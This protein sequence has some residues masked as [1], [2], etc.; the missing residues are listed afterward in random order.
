M[1]WKNHF[2]FLLVFQ[3]HLGQSL[4]FLLALVL[5][6]P[7]PVTVTAATYAADEMLIIDRKSELD[8]RELSAMNVKVI[9]EYH[10]FWIAIIR[11]QRVT[12]DLDAGQYSFYSCGAVEYDKKYGVALLRAEHRLPEVGGRIL[13][14]RNNLSVIVFDSEKQWRHFSENPAIFMAPLSFDEIA[15]PAVIPDEYRDRTRAITVKPFVQQMVN[16]ATDTHIMNHWE[17]IIS[18]ATT[19]YSTSTGCQTASEY[20][21]SLFESYS[22]T[23][24]FQYHSTG[25]APN[26][27]AT[28]P[29]TVEPEKVVIMIGHLDDLPSN[30]VAPGADD[31][32]SGSATVTALADIMSNYAFRKTVKFIAVTGEEFG[33][34]GSSYYASTAAA[35]GE[36][37]EAV[38]N[39]DMTGWEGDGNP[40]IENLD[41]NYNTNSQWLGELF[42]DAASSYNTGCSVNLL[43][44]P[45]LTASD[46]AP[47][48]SRG[49]SALCG[50]TDNEGYCGASGHYPYYHTSNDTLVNCGNPAFFQKTVRAYL[51]TLAHLADP[52]CSKPVP[53]VLQ[54]AQASGL[55]EVS[56]SWSS[57]GPGNNYL[58]FRSPGGCS[59][60]QG[61]YQVGETTDTSFVDES[62]SGDV[63]YAY[64]IRSQDSTGFCMSGPGNCLEAI[65]DG[66]CREPPVFS[67]LRSA[68]DFHFANCTIKLEWLPA[69]A[70]CGYGVQYN[71]Y[72]S[73]VTPFSPG[74]E[75]VL[76]T[77]IIGEVFY[78]TLVDPGVTYYYIVRSEDFS[79]LGTGPMGGN[80]DTN[81]VIQATRAS[82]PVRTIFSENFESPQS[83]FD[84]ENP[85][86]LSTAE[87]HSGQWSLFS[88]NEN[89]TCSR[90]SMRT[91]VSLEN[92]YSPRLI[93][94]S[95]YSIEEDYDGYQAQISIDNGQNW[96]LLQP[97]NG[98]P[99][100]ASADCQ[101]KIT[102]AVIS[103]ESSGWFEYR[104]DLT[105]YEGE[106]ILIR[107]V[108]M[109]D[110]YITHGGAY[111]DDVSIESYEPC[112]ISA[113]PAV[114]LTGLMVLVIFF[115]TFLSF[116]RVTL[117]RS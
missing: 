15:R 49:W 29:G 63:L 58:I 99:E 38:L 95:N 94:W 72:R 24:E 100:N 30:G 53:P 80:E 56:L 82:G 26:V 66:I 114:N 74:S 42:V 45:S 21:K 51:A 98:Y 47:F 113:V 75:T 25:H 40:Q 110:S 64:S 79:G 70:F 67:G 48:W 83:Q 109:S 28:L 68:T 81:T 55:N 107:F 115:T 101:Y 104:F 9:A 112:Q 44:C 35:N 20:V 52:L 7:L 34:Y 54:T 92:S 18:S 22:L 90:A 62:A 69:T 60:P 85:W 93:F 50:I 5:V 41:L 106:E 103:N 97:E 39:A 8:Q 116:L 27:I 36:Q 61:F 71:V 1:Y 105:A 73:I 6:L 76:A 23:A 78:D 84:C 31:N 77:G 3:N 102:N 111:I 17:N 2:P 13:W 14:T 32:A 86:S 87:V 16:L 96:S 19:R 37:I 43:Y 4:F 57:S 89:Y 10:S 117:Y 59:N 91:P 108:M 11:H 46:H 88:G 65:T 33:L 12:E